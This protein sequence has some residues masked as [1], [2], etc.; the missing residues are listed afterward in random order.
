MKKAAS[1]ANIRP[2]LPAAVMRSAPFV[3]VVD[4]EVGFKLPEL[5]VP[6]VPVCAAVTTAGVLCRLGKLIGAKDKKN[7]TYT[8][9]FDGEVVV[10]DVLGWVIEN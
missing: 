1:A 6:V 8:T 10:D 4:D 7:Q 3:V 2:I 5:S 9:V